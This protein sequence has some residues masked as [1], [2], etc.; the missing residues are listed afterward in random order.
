MPTPWTLLERAVTPDGVLELRARGERDL[1][2]SHDGRVLMSSR[3]HRSELAVAELGCAPIADRKAPRV[4]IGGLGLGFSLRAALD[5]LP[6]T[7][8]VTVAELNP[9]V[10]RWCEGPAAIV[11]QG[12]VKDRRVRVVIDDV[13]R[14]IRAAASG[15][16]KPYDAIILDLYVGPIDGRNA[17]RHPLYG[18]AITAAAHAA[19]SEGGVYAVWGEDRSRSFEQRLERAGFASR[20]V[21]ARGGGPRHAVYVAEKKKAATTRG[22]SSRRREGGTV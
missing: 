6:A 16:E 8:K 21:L 15:K 3:I 12:A 2:I 11:T 18:D 10:V 13:T 17:H 20:F 22:R 7:A 4:L 9:V 1:M 19:L 14:C 5:A